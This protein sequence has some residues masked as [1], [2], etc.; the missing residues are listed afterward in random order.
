MSARTGLRDSIASQP[1]IPELTDAQ[2]EEIDRRL[3][4][5]AATL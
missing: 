1:E 2:R 5:H 4:E 3:A